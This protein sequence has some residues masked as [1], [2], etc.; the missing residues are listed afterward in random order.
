[1][2]DLLQSL[3]QV[4]DFVV[5]DD[6]QFVARLPDLRLTAGSAAALFGPSGSGKTTLMTALFGLQRA[7]CVRHGQVFFNDRDLMAA[8]D[9]ELHQVRRRDMVF[10]MQDAHASLDPLVTVGRQIEQATDTN[11]DAAID[12]LK[13]LG[14]DDAAS[15]CERQPHRISGG[16][17]QRVLLAIAF[18]RRPSL[19]VADEP[20][21]SLDG[22]SYA[23]LLSQLRELQ[24]AGS[25]LLVATH[26]GRL[27]RD[28]AAEV[29]VLHG[30]AFLRAQPDQQPWP[31]PQRA[32]VGALPVLSANGVR[33]QFGDRVVLRR[34]RSGAASRRDRRVARRVRCR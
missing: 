27:L 9:R 24:R 31:D 34:H 2:S 6:R 33:V 30:R 22:G 19:V 4:S 17:A 18:L 23:E 21:A 16:Q 20:S 3:L 7:T 32:E 15:L 11:R 1:M 8:D 10:L 14:V 12:M 5:S 25:A 13:Q 29:Y 26:D 28:L